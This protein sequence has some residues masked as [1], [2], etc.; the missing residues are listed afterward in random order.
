[1]TAGIDVDVEAAA[2]DDVEVVACVALGDH[3]DV[4][5]GDGLLDKSA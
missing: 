3:F 2:L 1:M 4:F 5:C